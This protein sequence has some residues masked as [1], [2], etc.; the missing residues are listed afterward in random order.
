MTGILSLTGTATAL[1]VKSLA[2]RTI[3]QPNTRIC[4]LAGWFRSLRH[5]KRL[6]IRRMLA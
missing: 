6:Q 2:G 3:S 4:V 1:D 5:I